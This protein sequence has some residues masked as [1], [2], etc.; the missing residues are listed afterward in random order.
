MS[1]ESKQQED[2]TS[3]ASIMSRR[4]N[5]VTEAGYEAETETDKQQEEEVE[6]VVE[7]GITSS[8]SSSVLHESDNE[9]GRKIKRSGGGD[10]IGS[11]ATDN[12]N[13]VKNSKDAE[14]D[15]LETG[16]SNGGGVA[17]VEE[18][19]SSTSSVAAVA[20]AADE[21]DDDNEEQTNEIMDKDI[22]EDID[23][24][25]D[26]DDIMDNKKPYARTD[27]NTDNNKQNNS[28][29][30]NDIETGSNMLIASGQKTKM[31]GS[32]SSSIDD[33][34]TPEDDN[35]PSSSLPPSSLISSTSGIHSINQT[36]SAATS[37][38]IIRRSQSEVGAFAID[39]PFSS[40]CN[41]N[42]NHDQ[43]TT[44]I[45]SAMMT[46]GVYN[47]SVSLVGSSTTIPTNT[48]TNLNS[49]LSSG[50][51]SYGSSHF[52]VGKSGVSGSLV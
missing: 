51:G 28:E 23:G 5:D 41:N 31:G 24:N 22:K 30:N 46:D 10:D 14:T 3:T 35:F 27:K 38:K 48:D 39:S 37:S 17:S 49:Q 36:R 11:I 8:S 19:S 50:G 32:T 42:N 33:H 34:P 6:V 43:D 25:R 45:T 1:S 15:D 21:I 40:S 29:D 7:E 13:G 4:L 12:T 47:A 9:N 20:A 2:G 44:T 16:I 26:H 52:I 18:S